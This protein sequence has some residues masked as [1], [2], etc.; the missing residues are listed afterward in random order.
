MESCIHCRKNPHS[1]RFTRS[2]HYGLA[3]ALFGPLR[4]HLKRKFQL[5]SVFK[6]VFR[7]G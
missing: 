1:V 6:E 3:F 2:L 5:E 4:G 7:T